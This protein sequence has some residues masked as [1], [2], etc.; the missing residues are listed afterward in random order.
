MHMN[1]KLLIEFKLKSNCKRE[2]QPAP[3]EVDS[4]KKKQFR[5]FSSEHT[6]IYNF[7]ISILV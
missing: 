3:V 1:L 4:T 7:I 2:Q 6:L 5:F